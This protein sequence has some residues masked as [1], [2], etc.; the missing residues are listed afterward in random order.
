MR[1]VDVLANAEIV[2]LRHRVE[3]LEVYLREMR[4]EVND[5]RVAQASRRDVEARAS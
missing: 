1:P 2:R 4:A 3:L 5:L